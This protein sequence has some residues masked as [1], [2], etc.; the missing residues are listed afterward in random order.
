MAS[1]REE[2]D[3]LKP[4]QSKEED[5]E[6]VTPR[7]ASS[8]SDKAEPEPEPEQPASTDDDKAKQRRERFKALQARA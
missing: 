2:K 8:T 3:L 4:Q 6:D 5:I 7:P 1:A